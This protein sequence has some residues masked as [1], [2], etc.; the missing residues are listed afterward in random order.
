MSTSEA[1]IEPESVQPREVSLRFDS[2]PDIIRHQARLH[3]HDLAFV[4]PSRAW[5]YA[6]LDEQSNRIA[7]GLAAQGVGA[8][9]CVA[10]LTKCGAEC[11]LL[12]LGAGKLGAMLSPMNWRLADREIEY[13]ISVTRP[14][15]LLADAFLAAALAKVDRPCVK[16][17]LVTED[18]HGASSFAGWAESHPATDPGVHPKPE[19]GA[20]YLFSSGTTG[21]PKAVELSHRGILSHCEAWTPLFGYDAGNTVHL[22][23]LPTFHVSGLVNAVWMLYLHG[24]AV[25]YPHFEP[26]DW[27]DAISR[28][29]VTDSFAVPAML[30]AMV[31]LPNV[32]DYDLASLRSI[33]YGGSPIDEA[34]LTRCVQVFGCGFLQVFGMTECS[35]T[36]T[37]LSKE[38]HAPGG[39]R[40]H[41]LRSVGRPGPQFALRIVDPFTLATC[42]DGT[43]GEVWIRSVQNMTGY[44]GNPEATAAAFPQGRDAG[45]GWLRS[46][47]AGYLQDGYLYL[48]DRIKDM[49]ISGGENIYP[50]EVESVLVSHPAVA[51]VA[52]IGVPDDRWGETVKACVVFKPGFAASDRELIQFARERLAHYKCPTSVD[53]IQQLPRNPSGKVLKRILRE[54]YWKG[55]TRQIS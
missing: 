20:A 44:F 9:D 7:R 48:Q 15:V 17:D 27:L 21:L 16:L 19:D 38:D 18:G 49:I 1:D 47:D 26:H 4:S 30:R 53:C 40:A 36:V 46:G 29:G 37:L 25:F 5:T 22:N 11:V 12:L 55:R 34:L 31:E 28:H 2:I 39:A 3:P 10:C 33:G 50:I 14:K 35:G 8:G 23:V 45:G 54:P 43:V 41:L 52:V 24:R 13:V 32:H 51:E 6:Q 42:P